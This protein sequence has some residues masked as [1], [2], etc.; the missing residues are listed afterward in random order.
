MAHL[1]LHSTLDASGHYTARQL[2]YR[3][4]GK[5]VLDLVI[6]GAL[7]PIVLPLI[8]VLCVLVRRD[9]AP[10]LFAHRR[11]G[12]GGATFTCWKIRTM[13]PDADA[14]LGTYLAANPTAAAEWDRSQKLQHDPRTTRLG[15]RLRRTSLDELPQIWN[16]LR[17]EMSLVGP[18]P[19]TQ[20]ELARYG[21]RAAAYLSLKPGVT[22]LWQVAGRADGCYAERLQM[23]QTYA[24]SVGM[25]QDLSLIARTALVLVRPTGR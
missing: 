23:D 14:Q 6:A 21:L 25:F 17:G 3:H 2:V 5:R 24:L 11:I 9:G 19:V 7:L 10:G 1:D 20:P 12:K 22:G 16:V 8:A 13:V 18:R 15:R 4:F